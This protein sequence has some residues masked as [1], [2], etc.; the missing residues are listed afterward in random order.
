MITASASRMWPIRLATA[1]G[2]RAW[3]VAQRVDRLP[4][5]LREE[6][7][8]VLEPSGALVLGSQL[9]AQVAAVDRLAEDRCLPER[10]P[11]E[12]GERLHVAAASGDVAVDELG[13]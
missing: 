9:A 10:K 5:R 8:A 12:P 11:F 7:H 2:S 3:L 1:R 13:S 4:G 6:R